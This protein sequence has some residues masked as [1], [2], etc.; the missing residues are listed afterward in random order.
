MTEE[1]KIF[2]WIYSVQ[3]TDFPSVLFMQN[4]W[5]NTLFL[6]SN[7]SSG[8]INGSEL[9]V[10]FRNY[11]LKTIL[12]HVRCTLLTFVQSQDMFLYFG[13]RAT[14]RTELPQFCLQANKTIELCTKKWPHNCA[15]STV[16]SCFSLRYSDIIHNTTFWER[17]FKEDFYDATR[18]SC[19]PSPYGCASSRPYCARPLFGQRSRPYAF[20][21]PVAVR[22][23]Q[24]SSLWTSPVVS[25]LELMFLL[26]GRRPVRV[27]RSFGAGGHT[28][29]S[30]LQ[31]RN[32]HDGNR[33]T[34]SNPSSFHKWDGITEIAYKK[35]INWPGIG[36]LAGPSEHRNYFFLY[37]V[38]CCGFA[39]K[40]SIMDRNMLETRSFKY[41][42]L[43]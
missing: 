1:L 38:S 6:S 33:R 22:L 11:K 13:K 25:Q 19:C 32:G 39:L 12:H 27:V 42:I 5:Q 21:V 14:K 31:R 18:I 20:R 9:L 37:T 15:F 4:T 17:S 2:T 26:F 41:N 8:S 34:N 29:F 43:Y 7:E 36:A 30:E 24:Y 40:I 3:R 28:V 10:Q 16:I 35:E 23:I